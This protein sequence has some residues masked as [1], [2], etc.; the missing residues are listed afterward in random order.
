VGVIRTRGLTLLY[1][2]V[3]GIEDLDL[4]VEAGEVFG[5]LGPNGSGKTTTIRLLLDFIR[6]TR[7]SATLFGVG[8]GA[9]SVRERIGYLPGELTLDGRMTGH[10]MLRFLDALL[11]H[12]SRVALPPAARVQ[13]RAELRERLGLADRDLQRRIREYSRGMKQRLGLISAFQHDPDLLILDEPT[14]G[15]DPLI[16]EVVFELMREAKQRGA[17]VFHSSHVLS[18]VDRTCDRVAILRDGRLV[19]L[20]RVD[21]VRAR[22]ARRMVIEFEDEFDDMDLVV[23]GVELLERDGRRVTL[24]VAGPIDALLGRLARR[25]IRYLAFPESNVEEAFAAYYSGAAG[26]DDP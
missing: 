26:G 18:E 3:R 24:R 13:R 25:R 19:A 23:D 4:D 8:T 14:E 10:A 12:A 17:T 11:P 16:R 20:M 15:L 9:A 6:P 7:G 5:F 22:S 21:E 2:A 1:G